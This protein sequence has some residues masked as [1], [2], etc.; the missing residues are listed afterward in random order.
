MLSV[1]C[2]IYGQRLYWE[3]GIVYKTANKMPYTGILEEFGI[4]AGYYFKIKIKNGR[5]QGSF[6]KELQGYKLKGTINWSKQKMAYVEIDKIKERT[7]KNGKIKVSSYSRKTKYAPPIED[8]PLI[9]EHSQL[10][11]T[12]KIPKYG[13]DTIAIL[14]NNLNYFEK[15]DVNKP[16]KERL[17]AILPDGYY[18]I[19]YSECKMPA[20]EG[21]IQDGLIKGRW[22]SYNYCSYLTEE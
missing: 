20:L 17:R 19:F 8:Y 16:I 18:I 13:Q 5:P 2:S 14:E 6:V 10:V 22:K 4:E 7:Q 15:V 3:N 21:R 12:S 11:Q 9:F 1:A